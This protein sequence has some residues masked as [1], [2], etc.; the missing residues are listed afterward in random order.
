M[1]AGFNMKCSKKPYM[2]A[3]SLW[4]EWNT[5]KLISESKEFVV[6]VPN[7]DIEKDLILFWENHWNEIDKFKKSN[8][9]TKKAK[10]IDCLLLEDATINFECKLVKEVDAWDHILFIWEI[11]ASYINEDKKVLFNMWRKENWDRVFREF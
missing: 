8:L 3:V 7:K 2:Y 5:H 11:L 9:K 4:K 6:S 1:V 10:F